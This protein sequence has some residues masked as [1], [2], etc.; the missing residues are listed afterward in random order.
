M[1]GA[2]LT[3]TL[4]VVIYF[5]VCGIVCVWV[6]VCAHRLYMPIN[7]YMSNRRGL[8]ASIL[9]NPLD[10][11]CV[12]TFIVL[13]VSSKTP[14]I[15]FYCTTKTING[16]IQLLCSLSLW[17]PIRWRVWVSVYWYWPAFSFNK[18][19][20][21]YVYITLAWSVYINIWDHYWFFRW[22]EA[23]FLVA[24]WAAL[25]GLGSSI[26]LM[27]FITQWQTNHKHIHVYNT[28]SLSCL[29]SADVI[30]LS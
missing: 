13:T 29:I 12:I 15:V 23:I 14:V 26:W 6:G 25:L 20:M 4:P 3:H 2:Q 5:G 16:Q 9:S 11:Y 1:P 30:L 18:K 19:Y 28:W 22:Q 24:Y 17:T 7:M 10:E 21:T 27:M 8:K